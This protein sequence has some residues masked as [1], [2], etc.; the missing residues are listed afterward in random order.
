MVCVCGLAAARGVAYGDDSLVLHYT[1]DKDYG[2]DGRIVKGRYLDEFDG[3]RGVLRLDGKESFINC[4]KSDSLYVG[5]DTTF[6]MWVRLNGPIENRF[7]LIFGDV[8]NRSFAFQVAGY[9]SLVLYYRYDDPVHGWEQMVVPVDRNILSEK[10]SH[11]AVVVEYPRCRFYHNGVLVNDVFLPIPAIGRMGN[12]AKQIGGKK[13]AC[14]PID[15]DEFRLYRRA[16]TAEEVA[17]HAK[18]KEIESPQTAELAVEPDWYGDT[19]TLRLSCKGAKY[20]GGAAEVT[21]LHGDGTHAATPRKTTLKE[22]FKGSARYVASVEFPLG[23][24]KGKSLDG[25]ASLFAADGKPIGKVYRHAFLKKPDWVHTNEGYSDKVPPPWTPVEAERKSDGVEVRVWGRGYFFSPSAFLQRVETQGKNILASPV[26]LKARVDGRAVAWNKGRITLKGTS[27]TA[28]SLDQAVESDAATLRVNT[29]IEYDGYMIFDC[30]VRSRRTVSLDGLTLEIP[31]K[32]RYAKLCYG[33]RVLP[34]NRKI[35]MAAWYRGMV[36]GDLAFR[37][38]GNIWLGDE[39][40]GLVWQAESDEDWHYAD[41]QKAIEILPRGDTTTFKAHLVDVPTKLAAGESLRYKFVLQATPIKP[42]L[43]DPWDLRV[44]RQEPW[45]RAFNLPDRRTNGV[46]TLQYLKSAGFRHIFYRVADIWPYP[47]PVHKPFARALHR[48]IDETHA[49]GLKLYPYLIHERFPVM[50]PEFD[51]NGLRMAKRPTRWYVQGGPPRRNHPRPGPLVIEYGS[52]SQAC[53]FMCAK[54][55]ALQDMYIHSLARRL[56]EYGDDG[57]Y[58]DGTTAIVPCENELHG[59][60]YRDGNGK[61]R[62]NEANL[63]RG[64]TKKARRGG[65]RSCF[66]W[67][68]FRRTGLRRH[69]VDRGAVVALAGE[70]REEGAHGG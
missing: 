31:L 22:A 65:G 32:T 15:L 60:G 24:L 41:E 50:A 3:R 48:L 57:V 64:E 11:I 46:P 69:A 47:I 23:D 44:A 30:V 29:R 52:N 17:A 42:L 18:N 1:F 59:C 55:K 33:D 45:G 21:L 39:E 67:A 8:P 66:L 9:Q 40:R 2:N 49:S 5:G 58:L 61:I 19:V 34:K 27:R 36:K 37:F 35:P 28:A 54:S 14:C 13:G 26:T 38:S 16:L 25:A 56:D 68:E 43:R 12:L 4:G 53:L 70:G 6:E 10:W 20:R 62:P 51:L 63:H 7:A